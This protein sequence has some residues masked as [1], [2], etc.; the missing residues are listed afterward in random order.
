MTAGGGTMLWDDAAQER[1]FNR[2][3]LNLLRALDVLLEERNVTY[4]ANRLCVTQ[5]AM[6]AALQ[7]MRD[8]FGDQLLVRVGREMELTPRAR[9]LIGPVRDLLLMARGTLDTQ[10]SFDPTATRRFFRIAMSDYAA[11]VLM[12]RIIAHLASAAPYLA[13][14]VEGLTGA[15]FGKLAHNDVDFCISSDDWRLYGDVKPGLDLRM[16]PLFS[17][18]FVCVVDKASAYCDRAFSVADYKAAA[19]AAVRIARGVSSIVDRACLMAD[20]SLN[21]AVTAP[22]FSTLLLMIPGTPLV[23]TTQ[24]RL[25]KVMLRSL[26]LRELP[27]PIPIPELR[28]VLVW[29]TRNDFDPGHAFMRSVIE[30]AAREVEADGSRMQPGLRELAAPQV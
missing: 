16:A 7:R 21:V 19:H 4:A 12:P 28:E 27:C 2:F 6:S 3:D 14:H 23:A 15:S 18:S 26:P 5:P 13:C 8:F 29:H 25:A 20:L 30:Q 1:R 10:P 9:S 11:F 24:A 17:D 22:S